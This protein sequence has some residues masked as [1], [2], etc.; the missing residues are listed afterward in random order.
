MSRS[1]CSRMVRPGTVLSGKRS[2][3]RYSSIVT[4]RPRRNRGFVRG[5]LSTGAL[6]IVVYG[7][8][9]N[10]PNFLSTPSEGAGAIGWLTAMS[11]EE[12]A[13]DIVQLWNNNGALAAIVYSA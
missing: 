13:T 2:G 6:Q 9:F 8:P 12:G 5:E 10:G 4:G 7:W 3:D 11:N 1:I